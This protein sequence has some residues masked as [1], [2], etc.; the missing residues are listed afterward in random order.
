MTMRGH[1]WFAQQVRVQYCLPH[2][3][4]CWEKRPR[5]D[6]D[7]NNKFAI[8]VN[9]TNCLN[10]SLIEGTMEPALPLNTGLMEGEATL[11]SHGE[12]LV[13]DDRMIYDELI[14]PLEATM[15]RSIWRIV[16][17]ADIAEDCLQDAL[18]VVWKKRF[19]IRQHA[20]PQALILKICLNAAC[21]S[22]RRLERL[23]RQ[24]DL[25]QLDNAPAPPDH[26]ADRDLE[27]KEIVEQ[28]QLAIRRLPRKCALA[29]M[30]RLIHEESF[31]AIAHALDC[32]EI[33]VRIHISRGRAQLRKCLSHLYQSY[34][35]EVGS[36]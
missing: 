2:P 15:M 20:N 14:A 13:T 3:G 32:S 33:T 21:D 18:A 4:V 25:S 5:I 11:E 6:T 29:V 35:Q 1:L 8:R 10:G 12:G 26:D 7:S 23:R 16:R 28:V 30:M 17:N 36:E 19:Q 34:R 9:K 24:T 31:E 27:G 22:L